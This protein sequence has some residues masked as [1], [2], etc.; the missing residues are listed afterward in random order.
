MLAR[1]ALLSLVVSAIALSGCSCS[2]S[3]DP[4]LLGTDDGGSGLDGNVSGDEGG[5]D[6]GPLP[7]DGGGLDS[8]PVPDDAGVDSGPIVT[9]SG[10]T[11]GGPTDGGPTDGGPTDG[12]CVPMTEICNGADDDCDGMIDE[13]I[14]VTP[15]GVGECRVVPPTACVGGVPVACVPGSPTMEVCDGLDNDCNGTVDDGC[16]CDR[17]VLAGSSGTGLSPASPMGSIQGAITSLSAAGGG[18]VCVA[19]RRTGGGCMRTVYTEAVTMAEG[20]SVLGNHDTA[21]WTRGNAACVTVIQNV[22]DQGVHFPHSITNAT[23]LDG[24]TITAR[25]GSSGASTRAA[26]TMEAGGTVSNNDITGANVATSIGVA[27]I[28]GGGAVSSP[29][30]QDSVVRGGSGG[31]VTASS[32][33]SVVGVSPT[34]QRSTIEGGSASIVSNGIYLEDASNALVLD[35]VRIAGGAGPAS[36]GLYV[37][38]SADGIRVERNDLIRGAS[39]GGTSFGIRLEACT[40]RVGPSVANNTLI[41]GGTSGSTAHAI[42]VTGCAV[43]ITGNVEILGR[44]AATSGDARGVRCEAGASCN[45]RSNGRIV[46]IEAPARGGFGQAVLLQSG[47]TGN[48]ID[49]A[50]IVGCTGASLYCHG[51]LVLDATGTPLVDGNVVLPSQ[52]S[53]WLG[54]VRVSRSDATVSNNLVLVNGGSGIELSLNRAAGATTEAIVHSN[55]VVRAI[56]TGIAPRTSQLLSVEFEGPAAVPPN[57]VFRNNIAVCMG[58]GTSQTAFQ[59]FGSAGDPRLFENNDLYGCATLYWDE[60]TATAITLISAVNGLPG[61]QNNVSMD[62]SFV[63]PGTDYHIAPGSMLIDL[64]TAAGAPAVDF[65]DDVR[66]QGSGF[67]IGLDEAG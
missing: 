64:G 56:V 30:I 3:T 27:C 2:S 31:S 5:L 58:L 11:D 20:V 26:V 60:D 67:D 36:V 39:P 9:D 16:T 62:P 63:A 61:S 38:G 6:A 45:V 53:S 47:A 51:I 41:L 42:D 40:T 59:E 52:A 44:N 17:Y 50:I 66:P 18:I 34:I 37:T 28:D 49:N 65:D 48:V 33:V 7:T 19:A 10:P 54:G 14:P 22:N 57:G 32:A 55:T 23:Q 13:G 4:S 46:G 15:C 12:G 25:G 24:F 8:G 29:I 35:N 43:S 1:S 21:G